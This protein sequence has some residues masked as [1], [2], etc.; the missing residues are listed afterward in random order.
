MS[1]SE[2]RS[3]GIQPWRIAAHYGV[4]TPTLTA[5][6]TDTFHTFSV[7]LDADAKEDLFSLDLS[8]GATKSLTFTPTESGTLYLYCKPH[9][10]RGMTGEITVN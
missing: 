8:G 2:Q 1:G 6:S 9:E 3:E 4:F 7:K 10:S 5:T